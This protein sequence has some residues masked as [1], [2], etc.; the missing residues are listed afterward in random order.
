MTLEE[1]LKTVTRIEVI[2]ETGRA[3]STWNVTEIKPMLQDGER[4]LK[5]FIKHSENHNVRNDKS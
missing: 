2:D 5:L 4:T 3:Y 1:T